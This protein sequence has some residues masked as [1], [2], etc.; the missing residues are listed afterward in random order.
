MSTSPIIF[1]DDVE[2][3]NNSL[4]SIVH[5][6][7][8]IFILCDE[9]TQKHCLPLLAVNSTNVINIKAGEEHKTIDTCTLIW[10][11]L[12]AEN[13]DRNSLLINLGGG[14]VTDIGGFAAACYKRG[15]AYINIPTTLLA[16]VDASIG[17]KTGIDFQFYKNQIGVFNPPLSVH[18][19]TTFLKTLAP[20]LIKAGMAEVVKHYLIA[21]ATAF[22]NLN[23]LPAVIDR[24]LI[25]KAVSIKSTIVALDPYDKGLRKLL[26]FGHTVGH[27]IESLALER[28]KAILHGE[29]V[30]LGMAVETIISEKM[31]LLVAEKAVLIVN[32][33]LSLFDLKQ[34]DTAEIEYII[35]LIM[36]DKKNNHGVINMV[37]PTAIGSCQIDVAVSADLIRDA[38]A[39]YNSRLTT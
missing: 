34:I 19:C 21:D 33:L 32:K 20:D 11:K 7:S 26:N 28:G 38:I 13:A 37:L 9:N 23:T 4:H 1:Y 25:E 2:A 18:L 17:G 10:S 12:T 6:Y 14:V 3:L 36:Q 16:M 35:K 31:S 5:S 22:E 30:A 27:A 15:I 8:T 39:H 24:A 29:A